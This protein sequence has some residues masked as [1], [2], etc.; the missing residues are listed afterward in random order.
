[1]L[2]LKDDNI[3]GANV[4]DVHEHV[5]DH[6]VINM[7]TERS[8]KLGHQAN[9]EAMMKTVDKTLKGCGNRGCSSNLHFIVTKH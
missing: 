4:D 1:M 6:L 2:E 5:F 9:F 7:D 3:Q 8:D